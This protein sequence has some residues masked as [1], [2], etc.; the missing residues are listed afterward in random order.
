M[1]LS[2][3]NFLRTFC[4]VTVAVVIPRV[5][6]APAS[7]HL[8]SKPTMSK[9]QIV[10]SYAGDLWTVAKQGGVATRLTAGTGFET[11]AQF[12]PDGNTLAFTG[13]YDGNVDVFTMPANGGI[14]KRLTYHPDTD[15]VGGLDA[16][17]QTHSVSLESR[18]FFENH[19]ALHGLD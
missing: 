15:R 6:A 8:L 3:S 17:R 16:G 19:A 5:V 18:Q 13:E 10:F 12:S 7:V 11:E 1:Q 9:T 4:A 14:P 2:V